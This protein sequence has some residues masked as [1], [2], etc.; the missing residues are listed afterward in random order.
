MQHDERIPLVWDME[1]SDPD[2]FLTLLMLLGHPRVDLR[3]VTVTPGTAEQVG[4]VRWALRELGRDD[5][6]V[7]AYDLGRDKP[8]VSQWHYDAYG[9]IAPS[10]DAEPGPELLRRALRPGVTLVTGAALKNLGGVIRGPHADEFVLDRLVVQGGFAGEGVVPAE[11]QLE[12]FRGLVTCPSFN[13]NGDPK[14]VL[15]A[16]AHPGIRSRRFVSKNVC[17]GVVYDAGVHAQ[18]TEL[19]QRSAS[20]ALI[21]RGMDHYLRK[22]PAGKIIH[23]PLAACCA[24]D[25]SIGAWAEV[26]VYRAKGEWGARLAEG[27]RTFIIVDYDRPRF[28]ATF[29]A[30]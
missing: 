9:A 30:C 20:L 25:G 8:C 10:R 22:H 15:A 6:P 3:A 16:L 18:V 2:D 1:T 14:A 7:G 26:E 12:K 29:L 17:H 21:W 19:R 23:D 24:I 11:R 27:T 28:L 13:L 4:V 5:I